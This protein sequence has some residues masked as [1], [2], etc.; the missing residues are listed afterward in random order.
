MVTSSPHHHQGNDLAERAV[1]TAKNIIRKCSKNKSDLQSVLLNWRNTPRNN[2]LDSPNQRL[3]S[4]PTRTVIPTPDSK[5]ILKIIPN[6]QHELQRLRSHQI[7][8]SNKHKTTGAIKSQRQSESSN[9]SSSMETS[10]SNG[11]I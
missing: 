6:V 5:L 2:N 7:K 3:F 9:V 8:Y 10:S 11:Q 4:R 1:Q